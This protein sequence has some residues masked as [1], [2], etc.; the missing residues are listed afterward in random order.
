TFVMIGHS[1]ES[2]VMK[3]VVPECVEPVAAL[4][5]G[6][7]EADFLR[8]VLRYK[9][10]RAAA[11]CFAHPARDSSQN[12]IGRVIVNVLRGVQPQAV[13]M[14]FIDPVAGVGDDEFA[15]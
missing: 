11:C 3:I 9:E 8:L 14:K 1:H 10:S 7:N 6:L 4:V 13:E 12:V 2:A 15:D 5:A